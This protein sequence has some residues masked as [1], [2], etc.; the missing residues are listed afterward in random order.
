MKQ[1]CFNARC[2]MRCDTHVERC[3]HIAHGNE[4]R[5][6][7]QV[8]ITQQHRT[9]DDDLLFHSSPFFGLVRGVTGRV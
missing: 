9:T 1:I 4:K 6:E 8:K 3:T 2:N 7:N 5:K